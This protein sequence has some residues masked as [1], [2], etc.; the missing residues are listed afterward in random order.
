MSSQIEEHL[1]T[2]I[3]ALQARLAHLETLEM[4][5]VVPYPG[6]LTTGRRFH[7][8]FD[9]HSTPDVM[10]PGWEPT[11]TNVIYLGWE[12]MA[13]G[14][15]K[16][17]QAVQI[18]G[19]GTNYIVNS[20]FET[21]TNNWQVVIG[22]DTITRVSSDYKYGDYCAECALS[23]GLSGIYTTPSMA[24]AAANTY[25]API[26]IKAPS[27]QA[28]ELWLDERNAADARIGAVT[29][30][31]FTG[32]GEWQYVVA[33]KTF[34]AL[35]VKAR[36]YII[37]PVGSGVV[38]IWTDAL[39]LT[40]TAYPTPHIDGSLGAGH[41]W[42][43][44]AHASTST[45]AAATLTY[46]NDVVAHPGGDCYEQLTICGW[47][48]PAWASDI[49]PSWP[50]VFSIRG[51]DNANYLQL[52]Y[53]ESDDKWHALINGLTAKMKSV[54]QSF[55][56]W[57]S[58]FFA[59]TYDFGADSYTLTINDDTPVVSTAALT[60][61]DFGAN[62]FFIGCKYNNSVHSNGLADDLLIETRILSQTEIQSIY[63]FGNPLLPPT[64]ANMRIVPGEW[65][66][67]L[68]NGAGFSSVA[69][70]TLDL[71]DDCG[72]PFGAKAVS[73]FIM[74]RDSSVASGHNIQLRK[75]ATDSGIAI[76]CGHQNN[77]MAAG[78]GIVGVSNGRTIDY[79]IS[80]SGVGTN[81]ITLKIRAVYL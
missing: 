29:S 69:W 16:F 77:E 30:T 60:P 15:A 43:G 72:I 4:N 39:D 23:A 32:T 24:V 68:L 74:T 51:A 78:G 61:P 76:F 54:A 9:G 80:A 57:E 53:Q 52:H 14:V 42:T 38:T 28:M 31:A 33:T 37:N 62:A 36:V 67:T 65:T 56:P 47:F 6:I 71:V 41:A 13:K 26:W 58:Q 2:E 1:L 22:G 44:A 7:L 19:A 3:E 73:V 48:I 8:T 27:G 17:G 21:N 81:D 11:E 18:A 34:G 45:R 59:A 5:Y 10:E 66:S 25:T 64:H 79:Q 50:T 70:T 63:K 35:G 12:H 55:N 46:P 20:S 75:D 49:A 40:Q